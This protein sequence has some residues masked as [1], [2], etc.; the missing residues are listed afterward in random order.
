MEGVTYD[1]TLHSDS[2]TI[3]SFSA[4][5]CVTFSRLLTIIG[6]I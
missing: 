1:N 6:D 4:F 5:V 3:L 2:E